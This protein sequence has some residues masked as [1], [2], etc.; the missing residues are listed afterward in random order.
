[1]SL[2]YEPA[3]EP[4]GYMNKQVSSDRAEKAV[5]AFLEVLTPFPSLL[6]HYPPA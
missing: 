4:Q 5:R 2:K 1:M 3:S 6:I